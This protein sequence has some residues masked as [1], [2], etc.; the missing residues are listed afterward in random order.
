MALMGGHSEGVVGF[1]CIDR[2][3]HD[4]DDESAERRVCQI[5]PLHTGSDDHTVLATSHSVAHP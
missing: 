1:C 2:Q 3:G 4:S 5:L